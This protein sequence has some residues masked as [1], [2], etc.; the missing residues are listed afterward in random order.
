MVRKLISS[1]VDSFSVVT[2]PLRRLQSSVKLIQLAVEFVL[3]AFLAIQWIQGFLLV[4]L[5]VLGVVI[6]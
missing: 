6:G 3:F 5:Q 4:L 1:L 2:I